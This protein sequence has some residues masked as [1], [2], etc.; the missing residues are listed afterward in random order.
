MKKLVFLFF[1]PCALMLRAQTPTELKSWLPEVVGWSISD[2]VE[3]FSPD[4]LWDRI[5][6]SAPLFLENN[7]REMTA[8]EY[9]R[10]EDYITIQAYRHASPE[11]AFGMYA[12]ERSPEMENFPIG[13]EAQGDATNIYFFAANMYVKIWSHSSDDIGAILQDIAKGFSQKIDPNAAYPPL[14]QHFPADGKVPFSETYITSNYIGHEF[15]KGVY[16]ANY[17]K[18]GQSFQAFMIDAKTKDAAKDILTSYFTFTKQSLDFT[19]GSLLISDRYNGEI[20]VLWQGQY[21][22]GIFSESGNEIPD[23]DAFLK[24]LLTTIIE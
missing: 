12:S 24:A 16:T 5:N 22:L 8:M 9:T 14:V 2:K 23:S 15:L 20:P 17:E 1:L 19:D 21:I 3:V 10:R 7:F 13:G 4:N 11:D 18:N 6:G